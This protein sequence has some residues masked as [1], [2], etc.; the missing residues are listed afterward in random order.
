MASKPFD[1]IGVGNLNVDITLYVDRVP[2]EGGA[3]EANDFVVSPGGAAANFAVACSK[4]GLKAGLIGCVGS[5]DYGKMLI[6]DL[7]RN[8]VDTSHVRIVE[9]APTGKVIIVVT[10]DGERRMIAYR[11]A[12]LKL[13]ADLLDREY[14]SKAKWVYAASIHSLDLVREIAKAAREAKALFAWD[15]GSI[16]VKTGL[17]R[18][19]L[20][21]LEETN[22]LFLNEREAMTLA[23]A[24]SLN[25]A[26]R[27]L[28]KIG[29]DC[30]VVKR[31]V[32]G[33]LCCHKGA[34]IKSE[35]FRSLVVR[36]TTAAGDIFN[37]AFLY[38]IIRGKRI[39]EALRIANVAAAIKIQ[40]RG[41]RQSIPSYEEIERYM[42]EPQ[43]GL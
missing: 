6:D 40:G 31:G 26:I 27:E 13:S 41:A 36:D 25:E 34:V 10:P 17:T 8:K 11:G 23:Q 29:F 22:I 1:V 37:A 9:D 21:I 28:D 15:P 43:K 39:E 24:D 12:N 30:L 4:L 19:M 7:V 33:A 32:K 35:A 5:D 16:P 38:C 20:K 18:E 2:E 3:V 14:L 42:G